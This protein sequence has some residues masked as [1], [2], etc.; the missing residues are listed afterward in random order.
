VRDKLVEH[1]PALYR[2]V[3]RLCGHQHLAEDIAQETILRAIKNLDSLSSEDSIRLWLYRIARNTWLDDCK[4]NNRVRPWNDDSPEPVSLIDRDPSQTVEQRELLE[5]ANV[6]MSN[7]PEK[8]RTVLILAA[9]EGLSHNEIA[10]ILE[11]TTDAVKSNLYAARVAMRNA[12]KKVDL[13]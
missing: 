13:P 7:L 10:Q 4:K 3:Y 11:T 8:Q 6:V 1:L 5:M 9:G 2:F 12:F